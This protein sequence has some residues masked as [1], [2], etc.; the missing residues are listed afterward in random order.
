MY[1]STAYHKFA[2]FFL[3]QV[4]T[5][6]RGGAIMIIEN[7]THR[8]VHPI[9]LKR[10]EVENFKGFKDK[11]VWDLSKHRDY[12]FNS[13]LIQNDIVNKGIIYGENGAGKSNL[14]FALID[15]THH[16]TD[17][18]KVRQLYTAYTNGDNQNRTAKFSYTFLL[19]GIEMVYQYE[20]QNPDVALRERLTVDNE[21]VLDTYGKDVNINLPEANT[22]DFSQRQEG[23]SY[24]KFIRRN[25][26]Q[27]ENSII[28]KLYDFVDNM[29][30]FRSL[31]DNEFGGYDPNGQQLVDILVK[32]NAIKSF[33]NF[34]RER[35]L[36]FKLGVEQL[37]GRN[38]LYAYYNNAKFLFAAIASSGTSAL[39]LFYAWSFEFS[40]VR[41]LFID[42]FDAF[43]HYELSQKIVE[44]LTGNE[45][46]QAFVTSHNTGLMT[47][48]IYRPD[49]C[50]IVKNNKTITS[51]A[52]LTEKE[53]REAHNLE[54]LY[55]HGAF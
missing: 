42:E 38:E 39:W 31:R 3:R 47:N 26:A 27:I 48:S 33:E 4:L 46:M 6:M 13:G 51:L 7:N 17:N 37:N 54:K 10:F 44:Q 32:H 18:L 49:C 36:N 5:Y 50:F 16:L 12:A 30:W 52:D 14:G 19:D 41:F 55:K 1:K 40:K 23:M 25:G 20:K 29:L 43:Y 53:L 9:M 22:L 45:N 11:F 21:I 8:E 2:V 35:G 28:S 15:I 34:L 24:V